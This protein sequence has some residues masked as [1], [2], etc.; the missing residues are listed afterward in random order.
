L[1]ALYVSAYK[2]NRTISQPALNIIIPNVKRCTTG[3]YKFPFMPMVERLRFGGIR[4]TPAGATVDYSWG[5]RIKTESTDTRIKNILKESLIEIKEL[6]KKSITEE[7]LVNSKG[8]ALI[9]EEFSGKKNYNP[10]DVLDRLVLEY[11]RQES[12]GIPKHIIEQDLMGG[13]FQSTLGGIWD[14]IKERLASWIIEYLFPGQG[15]S[16]MA[17]IFVAAA[18][19][20]SVDQIKNIFSGCA[21]LVEFISATLVS[22]G[23]K[24]MAQQEGEGAAKGFMFDSVR[25]AL[26]DAMQD[27]CF[28]DKLKKSLEKNVCSKFPSFGD[29]LQTLKT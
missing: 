14:S 18:G 20:L 7:K 21:G 8:F 22:Y 15:D 2:E 9:I 24:K 13:L 12:I 28:T 1:L 16:E 27:Y 3:K 19:R 10:D 11:K 25:N 5:G 23:V 6:K 4:K 29:M 26:M 17:K